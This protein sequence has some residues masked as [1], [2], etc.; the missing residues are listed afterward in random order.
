MV[1][2]AY[3]HQNVP[4]LP[5]SPTYIHFFTRVRLK[6][7]TSL[8]EKRGIHDLIYTK[9]ENLRVS[10]RIMVDENIGDRIYV[11]ENFYVPGREIV[12]LLIN[13]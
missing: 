12:N 13:N 10:I 1:Y 2:N 4:I 5:Y 8:S 11:F 7:A 3:L 6:T 9:D